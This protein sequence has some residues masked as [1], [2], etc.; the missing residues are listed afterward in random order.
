MGNLILD[1]GKWYV[2]GT[3]G[4]RQEVSDADAMQILRSM[5]GGGTNAPTQSKPGIANAYEVYKKGKGIYDTANQISSLTGSGSQVPAAT[6]GEF[7]GPMQPGIMSQIGTGASEGFSGLGTTGSMA[8]Y[9]VPVASAAGG[10]YLAYDLGK[11]I[12]QNKIKK[13]GRGYARGAGQGAASGALI[14]TA[15]M[16][17]VGTAIGAGVGALAGGLG[18]AAG[19]EG[20]KEA[21]KR[22]WGELA[23]K[24]IL[25][26]E[27]LSTADQK[28]AGNTAKNWSFEAARQKLLSGENPDEFVGVLGNF[29][30]F[31]NDW[32][33]KYSDDQRRAFAKR[34][35][36]EGLYNSKKGDI[37]ISDADKAKK[38]MDEVLGGTSPVVTQPVTNLPGTI[39]KE[40][41]NELGAVAGVP[42][43]IVAPNAKGVSLL[44]T[45]IPGASQSGA[46]WGAP[47]VNDARIP[48]MLSQ[49]Q[50]YKTSRGDSVVADA[51]SIKRWRESRGR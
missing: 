7:I 42:T 47:T 31:G 41:L 40:G 27:G 38:I 29:E 12:H 25:V 37:F 9:A 14:G 28:S 5:E 32:L 13:T 23:E 45:T 20:T 21:Q 44:P 19:H 1:K 43:T 39:G 15:I 35:A 24:G 33:G 3:D 16:P 36:G 48:G 51:G 6:G 34:A 11:D 22:K 4:Q 49:L 26:P 46:M 10:A 17:G 18:V 50:S 30:T 2:V 8:S